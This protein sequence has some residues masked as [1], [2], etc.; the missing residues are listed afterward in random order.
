LDNI[1][2]QALVLQI[3][4]DPSPEYKYS[5]FSKLSDKGFLGVASPEQAVLIVQAVSRI[6]IGGV[7]FRG[8]REHELMTKHL[9]TIEIKNELA[10]CKGGVATI[11]EAMIKRNSLKGETLSAWIENGLTPAYKVFKFFADDILHQELLNRRNGPLGVD[12]GWNI[13]LYVGAQ[14]SKAHISQQPGVAAA[15]EAEVAE[16]RAERIRNEA[17][18]EVSRALKV[19]ADRAATEAAQALT[20]TE[21]AKEDKDKEDKD[22]LVMDHDKEE[23]E[24][25]SDIDITLKDD[26]DEAL[27]ED[28]SDMPPPTEKNRG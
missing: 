8:W 6:T 13:F 10:R 19:T 3:K 16:I 18:T 11:V 7:R 27:L 2:D 4:G 15:A 5:K 24:E 14:H 22:K 21:T 23:S 28:D 1:Q 17:A 26:D 20:A 9:V 12:Q 25:E